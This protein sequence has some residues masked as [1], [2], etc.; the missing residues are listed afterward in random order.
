MDTLNNIH[1]LIDKSSEAKLKIGMNVFLECNKHLFQEQ[2]EA[3]ETLKK[4]P[5]VEITEEE[6]KIWITTDEGL[7][8]EAHH[9]KIIIITAKGEDKNMPNQLEQQLKTIQQ[10]RNLAQELIK[11]EPDADKRVQLVKKIVRYNRQEKEIL[12][13][14]GGMK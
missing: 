10:Y 9:Y 3:L 6:E 2:Q 12:K 8:I 5:T 7:E 13:T 1:K 4:D 11:K 14:I